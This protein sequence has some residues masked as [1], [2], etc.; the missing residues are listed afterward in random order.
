LIDMNFWW[1]NQSGSY[2]RARAAGFI[3]ACVC[4]RFHHDNVTKVRAGD[5]VFS[6][7]SGTGICAVALATSSGHRATDAEL[8][9]AQPRGVGPWWSASVRYVDLSRPIPIA[10]V[11]SQLRH[12]NVK[13]GLIDR[14]GH[15][16][17][18]YLFQLDRGDAGIIAK[19]MRP[20][21]IPAELSTALKAL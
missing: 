6:Y 11:A 5:L 20:A 8:A 17:L 18:G 16:N 12:E 2:E 19:A 9:V 7:V 10:R 21:E 4:D 13:Y 1:A 3:W 14:R 15:V